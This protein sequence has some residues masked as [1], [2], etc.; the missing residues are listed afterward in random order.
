MID[1]TFLDLNLVWFILV[2]ILFIGY[3]VLDGFDLGVG[4]MHVFTKADADR[5]VALNAIGPVW[6]GNEVWLITAAGALFAAFP[7]VYATLASGL[8]MVVMLLLC[9]LIFRAVSIEF[10][11]K[12]PSLIW[13]RTWDSAFFI[14]SVTVSFILG[15]TAANLVAGLPIG[16]DKEYAGGFWALFSPFTVLSGI[17]TVVL[18]MMH[19]SVYLLLKTEG[20]FQMWLRRRIRFLVILLIVCLAAAAGSLFWN[21][22]QMGQWFIEQPIFLAFPLL[23]IVSLWNVVGQAQLEKDASAMIWSSLVVIS[24]LLMFGFRIF[25][26]LVPSTIDSAYS[27][28]VY[29]A[30]ASE[31]SLNTMLNI[32]VVGLPFVLAY[33]IGIYWVFRGKVT[34]T[35][36]SY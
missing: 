36:D 26:N 9:C 1:F 33:T 10:R 30:A 34:I 18:F 12:H 8:Y 32:A 19:G 14:S 17:A 35:P 16:P 2:G 4:A 7:D 20:M 22:P 29:S 28:G 25:P 21:D 27:L 31:T 23:A 6:D 11:G 5:R 3:A 13:K 24:L 15:V